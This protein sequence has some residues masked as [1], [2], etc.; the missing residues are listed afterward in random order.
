MYGILLVL[1][2]KA[3]SFICVETLELTQK[4]GRDIIKPN[5]LH[6][7]HKIKLILRTLLNE[8]RSLFSSELHYK[9]VLALP[10]IHPSR[11]CQ[12]LTEIS[13]LV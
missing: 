9:E 8:K 10:I 1:F 13:I 2:N 4:K 5:I 12:P 7:L 3:V 6:L 11:T